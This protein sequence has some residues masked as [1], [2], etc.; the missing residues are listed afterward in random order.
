MTCE[1]AET[2]RQK[3]ATI[4]YFREIGIA[5]AIYIV[6]V[7]VGALIVRHTEAPQWARIVLAILPMA[8]ALLMLRA[9][10]THLNA[11]DEF[12]RRMQTD[13]LLITTGIVVFGSFAYGFLEEWAAFPRAETLWFFPIFS[14]LF[15]VVHM[16]IRWRNR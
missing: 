13:A 12:Q 6:F 14:M 1:P 2:A 11:M 10:L 9:Y 7:F 16:T 5:G 4:R 15:A 8:P 3:K